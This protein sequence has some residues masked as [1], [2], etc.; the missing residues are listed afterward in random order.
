MVHILSLIAYRT[1]LTIW[2]AQKIFFQTF[3]QRPR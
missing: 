3:L 2:K 1:N